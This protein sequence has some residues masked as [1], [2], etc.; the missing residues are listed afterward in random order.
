[1]TQ[2]PSEPPPFDPYR[3]S[4]QP[5]DYPQAGPRPPYPSPYPGQPHYPG[6]MRNVDQYT[7]ALVRPG[8]VSVAF[9][10]WLLSALSWPVGTVVRTLAEDGSFAG[11]GPVMTLFATGC[12]GIAGVWGAVAF[13]GGSYHA[14]LGL[15]GGSMVIGV[16]GLAAAIVAARDGAAEPLSWVVIVLRLVLPAGAA[17]FSFLPGTRYYFAGNTA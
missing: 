15:C 14:R 16:L 9:V 13:L 2:P 4:M 12:L 6:Q 5:V 1:M 7:T 8:A 11:F 10:L 3:Q 17:V